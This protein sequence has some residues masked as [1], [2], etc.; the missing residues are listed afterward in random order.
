MK[1]RIT[2]EQEREA[3]FAAARH[4]YVRGL[5]SPWFELREDIFAI[6]DDDMPIIEKL[7]SQ[8]VNGP[9]QSEALDALTVF[10][11]RDA[12]VREAARERLMASH[13]RRTMH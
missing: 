3:T 2:P 8:A 10:F 4:G 7:V 6:T 1:K 12:A 9:W 11:H 5:L 13:G